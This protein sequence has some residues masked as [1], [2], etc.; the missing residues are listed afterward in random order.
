MGSPIAFLARSV[1]SNFKD[2]V[3]P[4]KTEPLE[5]VLRPADGSDQSPIPAVHDHDHDQTVCIKQAPIPASPRPSHSLPMRPTKLRRGSDKKAPMDSKSTP[6][7]KED[8][9]Y[10]Y[11]APTTIADEPLEVTLVAGTITIAPLPPVCLDPSL[12][13]ESALE[14]LRRLPI[15]RL[16]DHSM[17]PF[18][19]AATGLP[20]LRLDYEA[21]IYILSA[22][23]LERSSTPFRNQAL[24]WRLRSRMLVADPTIDAAVQLSQE[25]FKVWPHLQSYFP[26]NIS[27]T[28]E[29]NAADEVHSTPLLVASV[30]HRQSNRMSSPLSQPPDESIEDRILQEVS[31]KLSLLMGDE[32]TLP[33]EKQPSNPSPSSTPPPQ[34]PASKPGM[35]AHFGR[36]RH[37]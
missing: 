12:S 23:K 27:R 25:V 7:Y 16:T 3:R 33:A 29:L 20:R 22:L 17:T 32:A 15:Q 11:E 14:L 4:H 26:R 6:P 13:F 35:W 37:L 10:K 8:I 19:D 36:N 18:T 9:K 34:P 31:C 24:I 1:V 21:C 5:L 30:R 2:R 28:L